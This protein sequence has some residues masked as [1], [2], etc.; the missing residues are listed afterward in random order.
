MRAF[1]AKIVDK[2][3]KQEAHDLAHKMNEEF[4]NL[5]E[6]LGAFNSDRMEYAATLDENQVEQLNSLRMIKKE[7]LDLADLVDKMSGIAISQHN[8]IET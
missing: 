3:H 2:L 4:S 6:A 8:K 5:Q 7:V 1:T